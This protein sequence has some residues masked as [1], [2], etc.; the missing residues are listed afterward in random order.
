MNKALIGFSGFVGSTLLKQAPFE[1]L[2]RS[3]NIGEIEGNAFD[4]VI[5][6]GAPAQKWIAN[7]EPEADREKIDGLIAHLKTIQCKTFILISTVDVFKNPVEVDEDTP[8]DESGL[9]AYGL[10]R[11]LLEK[12]VESHFSRYLIVRLPGLVGPGLRKNVIF[13]FLN[14][15]NLHSIDSRGVFQF[16]PMINLWYDIQ[17]ALDAGLS[18]VHLTAEPI[19]VAD[20][21]AQGFGKPFE[22]AQANSPAVYD[23]RT[24]YAQ[25]FGASG[26]YQYNRRETVQAVRAYAQSEPRTLKPAQGASS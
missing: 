15:N 8:I 4:T 10:H 5:C 9:H 3:T 25:L 26:H 16:Y 23:M 12:F 21:S 6:A 17:A 11:R 18:L 2:Y 13:D 24:R 20:V 22:Q 1:A 7:R 14:D 19:S